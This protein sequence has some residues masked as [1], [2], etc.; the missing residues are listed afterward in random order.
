MKLYNTLTLS[1]ISLFLI[2]FNSVSYAAQSKEVAACNAAINKGDAVA[3][4]KYSDAILK[5]NS[6][7]HDGLLCKGRALG[8]QGKYSDALAYLE[9]APTATKDSFEQIVAYI[10]LGNLHKTNQ[11]Y[12]EA[13]AS[14]TKSL[15]ICTT[16]GNRQFSHINYNLMG[17]AN[18]QKGDLNA[19]VDSYQLAIRQ[20]NNDQE[21]GGSYGK[22][23]AAYSALGQHDSAIEY[24]VKNVVIQ[25]KVGSLDDYVN[26]HFKLGAYFFAAKDY[27]GAEQAYKKAI[28][29]SKDNGGAYYEA[30]G[31][32]YL[33]E[34]TA[35][36]GDK[37]GAKTLFTEA[38][39]IAKKIGA[40]G[41]V[42]DIDAT[43]KKLNI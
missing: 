24:Q 33:A 1:I 43:E 26:A 23:A 7:N 40:T 19:A 38:R 5:E 28:K 22:L 20:A 11:K 14:Y 8:L 39:S 15:E 27:I 34:A 29:F 13:I 21:R 25:Q 9:K 17:D 18:K 36:N 2:G 6:A 10:L 12:T 32:M 31:T 30:K 41:L 35:A 42:G 3:A 16:T 4:L 37:S